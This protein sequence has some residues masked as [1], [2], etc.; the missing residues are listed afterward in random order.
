MKKLILILSALLRGGLRRRGQKARVLGRARF[1]R[2]RKSHAEGRRFAGT[3]RGDAGA[4]QAGAGKAEHRTENRRVL[5][6]HPAEHGARRQGAGRE[7][8]PA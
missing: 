3:P 8:F 7:F 1:F 5:R 6:L 2:R 4:N